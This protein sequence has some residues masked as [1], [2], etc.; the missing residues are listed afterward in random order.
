MEVDMY[1]TVSDRMDE[2]LLG[3]LSMIMDKSILN[4]EKY[5]ILYCSLLLIVNNFSVEHSA[6]AVKDLMKIR[7]HFFYR[8]T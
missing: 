4:E 1:Q 2:V 8:M 6:R 7:C 3:L 5:V